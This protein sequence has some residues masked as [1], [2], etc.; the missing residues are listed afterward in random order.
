MFK[1]MNNT[2]RNY[3]IYDKEMLGIMTALEEWQQYL[4]GTTEDFEIRTD[5]QNLQYFR[6]LQKLN[7]QQ[8]RWILGLGEY[9]FTL[10]HKPGKTNVKPDILLRRPDLKRGENDNE[11]I[12]MLKEHH[13]RTQEFIFESLDG[14]FLKRVC[15]SR[16]SRDKIVEKALFGKEKDWTEQ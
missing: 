6:K 10:H 4:M 15:A 9:N 13:F 2:Q 16:K 1:A 5:H 8:A 11:D 12:T 14:D 3:K 7:R